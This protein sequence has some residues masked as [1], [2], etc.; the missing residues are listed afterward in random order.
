MCSH[1]ARSPSV[2]MAASAATTAPALASTNRMPCRV[3][4][5]EITWSFR[6]RAADGLIEIRA[7]SDAPR[8]GGRHDP[9]GAGTAA[10]LAVTIWRA[11]RRLQAAP[12]WAAHT[13][14]DGG[15]VWSHAFPTEALA[16]LGARLRERGAR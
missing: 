4:P 8:E 3:E 7:H 14:P 11:M 16:D 13:H 10:E 12:A 5:V 9:V 15:R 1:W 2:K 6:A